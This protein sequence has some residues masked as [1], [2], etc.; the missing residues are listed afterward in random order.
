VL[1]K[2]A[3]LT[4]ILENLVGQSCLKNLALV[5]LFL[6]CTRCDQAVDGDFSLLSKPVKGV[7]E[8]V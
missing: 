1:R 7:I 8:W 5:D 6:D 2:Q 4:R 3:T